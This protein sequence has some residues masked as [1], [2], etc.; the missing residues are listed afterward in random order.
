MATL[1]EIRQQYPQYSDMSDAD[2][3]G[4]L[5]QKFYADMPRDQFDAKM[6]VKPAK[7]EEDIYTLTARKEL[8]DREAK[9]LPSGSGGY[10]RRIAQGLT[11]NTAD[12]ILA[13]A[14]T[15][16]EM[17]KRGTWNPAEGYR[18]AKAIEDI[19]MEDNRNKTGLL[20]TAAEIGGGVFNPATVLGMSARLAPGA[21]LF[22]R[23]GAG[24][25]DAAAMGTVAGAAEGNTLSERGSN[26]LM[27]GG[28]GAVFG[29]GAPMLGASIKQAFA[30]AIS[31]IR[32][33][34][35]PEGYA[36]TQ[37]ARSI[38]ESGQTPAQ[39]TAAVS[40]AAREGQ[41]MYTLADAM[42]NTGQTKLSAVT[43][44]PGAGRTEAVDFLEGRQADQGRRIVNSLS[45]GFGVPQT[46]DRLRAGMTASRD[47]AADA[48]YGAARNNAA[49]VNV[50]N[51][52]AHIDETLSPGVNQIAR[53]QSGIANDSIESALDG[54][55]SRLTDGRSV[56]T[57]FTALQRLRGDVSDA[58][59]T[60]T[61]QG[62][63]NKARMLGGVLRQLDDSLES[64]STGFRDANRNFSR[65]S[66]N[67]EQIDNGAA[68]A[69]RGRPEDIVP[70]FRALSPNGQQAFR[71]GY[72]D[73]LIQ[74]AQG[75]AF[76]V[77]KARELT[78]SAFRDEAAAIA[79]MRTGAQ[80]QRQ[81]G[82][83]NT[84][85]ET[86]ARALGGSKTADNI[87]EDAAMGVDPSIITQV[88]TGN[89]GGAFKSIAGAVSNGWNGN[90]AD[91]RQAVGQILLQRG[92]NLQSSQ[93]QQML[94]TVTQRIQYLQAQARRISAGSRGAVSVAPGAISADRK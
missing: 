70:A 82:R 60:A 26:A 58:V 2:L 89:L 73:P 13:A 45:E 19:G 48:A 17:M 51:V 71:T 83:E 9:G 59:Q 79:P 94:D 5:H 24:A 25:V 10:A 78:G 87:N 36:Q 66:R 85:F 29:F 91:V 72:A 40:Q 27:G 52:I 74:K 39:L 31:N 12:E 49:P 37:V 44:S 30:P 50:S 55:R 81:I 35:N 65:A 6:G 14:T 93:V 63:G 75:A 20:G 4:A 28:L 56:Q 8:A 33:R 16:F 54:F 80:M 41:G 21:G 57:D 64:A 1:E 23:T 46:P 62:Q 7:A 53:P 68:A 32:A 88:L 38:M 18:Y 47:T 11:L 61:R 15:P 77:N 90:T 84:M 34:M 76:G 92:A 42:G 43:R 86:R 3:A 69:N 22:S 67:I